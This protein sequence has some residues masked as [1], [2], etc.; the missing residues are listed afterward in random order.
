MSGSTETQ[1]ALWD[2]FREA[3]E[4]G[5]EKKKVAQFASEHASKATILR[6]IEEKRR[7]F[8]EVH[9]EIRGRIEAAATLERP[10]SDT[11]ARRKWA[12][13][14]TFW[15]PDGS[16]VEWLKATPEQLRDHENW[17]LKLRAG[18]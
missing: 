11:T 2:L 13:K 3:E 15:I 5:V 14:A 12:A 7:V 16:S 17:Q 18:H 9:R 8:A 6:L 1:N 10:G 4:M